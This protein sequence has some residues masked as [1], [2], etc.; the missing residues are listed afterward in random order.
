MGNYRKNLWGL[1]FLM[2]CG[3]GFE[4]DRVVSDTSGDL[5]NEKD[6]QKILALSRADYNTVSELDSTTL[7]L[8][9]KQ[10]TLTQQFLW[11]SATKVAIALVEYAG[12][13]GD[14][15]V[16]AKSLVL[17]HEFQDKSIQ[18]KVRPYLAGAI[19]SCQRVGWKKDAI[20]LQTRLAAMQSNLGSYDSANAL[21]FS[22][23]EQAEAMPE[24]ALLVPIYSG[25]AN[26][27]DYGND[28]LKTELYFNKALTLAR[29][30]KDSVLLTR[31]NHDWA[32]F[33]YNYKRDSSLFFYQQALQHLNPGTPPLLRIRLHYNLAL[34]HFEQ[35]KYTQANAFFISMLNECIKQGYREGEAVAYKALGFLKRETG[36]L[37][38]AVAA[39]EKSIQIADSIQDNYLKL[40]ALYELQWTHEDANQ[41]KEALQTSNTIRELTNVILK[42]EKKA[43]MQA[44]ELSYQTKEKTLENILLKKEIRSGNILLAG[45]LLLS[46]LLVGFLLLLRQRNRILHERNL[47]QNKIMEGYRESLLQ[48]KTILVNP[49][50]NRET[51]DAENTRLWEKIHQYMDTQA[52]YMN[53]KIKAE[54]VAEAIQ[55]PYRKFAA[56]INQTQGQNFSSLVNSYRVKK[57][58]QL[59]EDESMQH[60]KTETL[61]E[62]AGF[63][64]RQS[65]TAIFERSVG[66]TPSLYRERISRP[67]PAETKI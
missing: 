34:L 46:G 10:Q 15:L 66:V 6:A 37:S 38:S 54:D 50:A 14:T 33:R 2:L 27:F 31:A 58:R 5:T 7:A 39:L 25:L 8:L 24:K 61:G 32:L 41:Y 45:S 4:N 28:T 12:P 63:G 52:P 67:D 29:E 44:L 56:L 9:N 18:N 59:L 23:L 22:C 3:C 49:Q 16:C 20:I 30:L 19:R 47:S 51:A 55:I 11:D 48:Q 40:Q 35:K 62:M 36:K 26:N 13:R 42:E 65:F 53:P 60:I 1:L 21:L 17:L 43:E 64:T 57:A